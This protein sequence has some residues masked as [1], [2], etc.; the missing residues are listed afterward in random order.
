MEE[1][2]PQRPLQSLTRCLVRTPTS[3]KRRK[4]AAAEARCHGGRNDRG[5]D[6]G[7]A[8]TASGRWPPP[9]VPEPINRAFAESTQASQDVHLDG[10]QE[11]LPAHLF[12]IVDD[13][14][15]DFFWL[16]RA[17][18]KI[19][20]A[21]SITWARD[22]AEGIEALTRL[23]LQFRQICLV[24]DIQLP[25]MDGFQLIEELQNK[26]LCDRV[27]LV[28]ITGNPN[29]ELRKRA[30]VCGAEAFFLKPC[31]NSDYIEIARQLSQLSR[32]GVAD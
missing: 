10:G 2:F 6:S 17:L 22:G 23:S 20:A 26:E 8:P 27:K 19:D 5:E 16:D 12:L 32:A 9:Q 1:R 29:P 21:G 7:T 30:A 11:D 25:D 31:R 28:F 13:D 3:D 4:T 18:K 24:V 14:R 15:D